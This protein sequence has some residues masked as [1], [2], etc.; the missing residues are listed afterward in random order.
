MSDLPVNRIAA[1]CLFAMTMSL[2]PHGV[3]S[4]AKLVLK[5]GT[6]IHGEIDSLQNA[7]YTVKSNSLGTLQIRQQDVQVIDNASTAAV[8]APTSGS[9]SESAQRNAVQSKL[10]QDPTLLSKVEALQSDPDV[11]AILNDPEIMSTIASGDYGV[12]MSH[13]KII[14]LMQNSQMQEIVDSVK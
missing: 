7:V 11:L 14:A 4:A 10:T 2:G 13:P 8:G 12:L 1:V 9:M 3:A 5:D 6:V